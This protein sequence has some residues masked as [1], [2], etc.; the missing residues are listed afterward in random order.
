MIDAE[1][2]QRKLEAARIVGAY[3]RI[4]KKADGKT[5][6]EHLKKTLSTDQ[7]AFIPVGGKY[8]P[9][10]ASLRDGQRSVVLLIESMLKTPYEDESNPNPKP[11]VKVTKP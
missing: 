1:D 4:F 9:I 5:V 7:P 11:K 6:L 8:C 2:Q 10:N 3:H